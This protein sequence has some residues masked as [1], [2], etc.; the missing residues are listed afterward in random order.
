M[1]VM[2]AEL[3]NLQG[4]TIYA[5]WL[6]KLIQDLWVRS[7]ANPIYHIKKIGVD[8]MGLLNEVRFGSK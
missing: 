8:T 1:S 6:H 3:V 2:A 7:I 5:E 4:A